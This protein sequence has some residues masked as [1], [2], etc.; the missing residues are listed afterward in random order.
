MTIVA[1]G[2]YA[3][4]CKLYVV[5]NITLLLCTLVDTHTH[6]GSLLTSLEVDASL[7]FLKISARVAL[8]PGGR[9]LL[10]NGDGW[11]GCRVGDDG[12]KHT[13]P[14]LLVWMYGNSICGKHSMIYKYPIVLDAG[15]HWSSA[16]PFTLWHLSFSR[17][18]PC[19]LIPLCSHPLYAHPLLGQGL[20]DVLSHTRLLRV[21]D[22]SQVIQ[23]LEQQEMK[24]HARI[25]SNDLNSIA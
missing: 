10:I 19:R 18:S 16:L 21:L 7:I 12:Y 14:M 11:P 15:G 9:D 2:V 20:T 22:Q 17:A 6:R 13:H 8:A 25:F 23:D 5:W 3:F 4:L 24:A 1:E